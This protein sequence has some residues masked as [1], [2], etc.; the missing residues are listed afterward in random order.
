MI[1]RRMLIGLSSLV[2]VFF[3]FVLSAAPTNDLFANRTMLTGTDVTVQGNNVGASEESGENIGAFTLRI[4]TVWYTWTAPTMGVVH[5]T[6][7]VSN[8]D[9]LFV[10]TAFT[11]DAVSTLSPAP[12]T[13][14]GNAVVSAG[15]VLQ[16][17][18]GSL[19]DPWWGWGGGVGDFSLHLWLE[20]P[21]SHIS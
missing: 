18:I 11:G 9:F 5:L 21:E 13:S 10:A 14:S 2:A 17:Q 12:L 7:T 6:G 16:I 3:A 1:M 15:T 20:G 4:H 8:P 19:Y